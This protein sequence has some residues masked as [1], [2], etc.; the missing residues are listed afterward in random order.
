MKGLPRRGERSWTARATS[1][2]PVPDSPSISTV[3]VT[4]AICSILTRTSWIGGDSPRMPVRCCSLRRSISRRTV[5]V[6]SAGSTGFTSQAVSPSSWP[7][8]LGSSVDSTSPS[9]ETACSR[10]AASSRPAVDSCKPPVRIIASGS[11]L[12]ARVSRPLTAWRTSSSEETMAVSKPDCSSVALTR[13]AC[14]K[15]SV[16]M[17]TLSAMYVRGVRAAQ[18]VDGMIEEFSQH[19]QAFLHTVRGAWKI[20]DESLAAGPGA[21]AGEPGAGEAGAGGRANRFGNTFGFALENRGGRFGGDIARRESRP[22]R[23]EHDVDLVRIGPARQLARNAI[24]LVGHNA[25]H[26][27]LVAALARPGENRVAGRVGT[28]ADNAQI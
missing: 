19:G 5:D 4:G 13:T 23:R 1:S 17:R 26:H 16:V 2:L 12:P 21:A 24:G 6:T 22:A 8:R 15:S 7:M 25:A 14:S 20:H 9:V 27:D 18:Q 10:A 28:L 11:R 3:D